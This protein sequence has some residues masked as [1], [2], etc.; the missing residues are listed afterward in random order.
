MC[1]VLPI[2]IGEEAMCVSVSL[3]HSSDS[4]EPA[5]LAYSARAAVTKYHR[6]CGLNS[7][8]LFSHGCRGWKSKI[9]VLVGL[10]SPKASFHGWQMV[11]FSL[12]PH[13][14]FALCVC[15][16]G[17]SF[18]SC[19]DISHIGLGPNLKISFSLNY[20]LKA[21]SSNPATLGVKTST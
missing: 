12:C 9:K 2:G 8:S 20:S 19:K 21:L 3:I 7:G 5:V 14:A 4:L 13:M 15:L 6:P 10:V 11:S 18:S 1:L 17:V 16:P